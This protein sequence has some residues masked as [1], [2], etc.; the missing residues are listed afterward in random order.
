MVEWLRCSTHYSQDT[1]SIIIYEMTLNKSLKV[2][3]SRMTHSYRASVSTLDRMD[4]DTAVSKK[5]KDNRKWLH[6][7]PNNYRS[8]PPT[9]NKPMR[10]LL[11]NFL[12]DRNTEDFLFK[13]N[14]IYR[15]K[16]ICRS[17]LMWI[18]CLYDSFVPRNNIKYMT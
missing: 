10:R 3:L 13:L 7:N 17:L 12:R 16:L 15:L 2:K 14:R 9:G 6:V 11:F 5:E 4:A 8:W 18:A 1:V